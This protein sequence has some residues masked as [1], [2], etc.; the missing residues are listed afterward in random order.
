MAFLNMLK[1][2]QASRSVSRMNS[3]ANYQDM[4]PKMKS[5][6]KRLASEGMLPSVEDKLL[7]LE[8][9]LVKISRNRNYNNSTKSH[10]GEL[11]LDKLNF[12]YGEDVQVHSVALDTDVR[13]PVLPTGPVDLQTASTLVNEEWN[14]M[15]GLEASTPPILETAQEAIHHQE[16]N[17]QYQ[18]PLTPPLEEKNT[19]QR[20]VSENGNFS[21]CNILN[22]SNLIF[23]YFIEFQILLVKS[24]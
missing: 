14:H 18:L 2:R 22:F 20:L 11:E 7:Y 4:D 19:F 6:F 1:T 23:K 16:V 8:E 5:I 15:F 17:Q 3:T 21:K 13:L 9:N 24:N 12:E 10:L